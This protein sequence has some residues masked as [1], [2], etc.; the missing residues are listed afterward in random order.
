ML[1]TLLVHQE[2]KP[3]V[4]IPMREWSESDICPCAKILAQGY[5]P[6]QFGYLNMTKSDSLGTPEYQ[7]V[8]EDA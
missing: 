2:P 8:N 6:L 1:L 7:T 5:N 4:S 3:E